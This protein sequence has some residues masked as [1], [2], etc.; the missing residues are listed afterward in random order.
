MYLT[1]TCFLFYRLT[2]MS[3]YS[4]SPH[5]CYCFQYVTSSSSHLGD[6]MQNT[7]IGKCFQKCHCKERLD[8]PWN[9]RC[10]RSAD[11]GESSRRSSYMS[12]GTMSLP[13]R[14]LPWARVEGFPK[15]SSPHLPCGCSRHL[16]W[17]VLIA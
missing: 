14:E 3:V 12:R 13:V 2:R 8:R 16:I 1:H 4:K 9:G 6:Q 15:N 10:S 5:F 7:L 17:D 11:V